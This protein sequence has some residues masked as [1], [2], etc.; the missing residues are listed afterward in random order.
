[1]VPRSVSSN[2]W[3]FVL[4]CIAL[5]IGSAG[6]RKDEQNVPTTGT[7]MPYLPATGYSYALPVM[8]A[9]F[10]AQLQQTAASTMAGNPITDA[11][12][13]LGR[14]LF[15]ERG[16][17]ASRTI[18]CGSCH[19]Q[20]QG[21]SD[22]SVRSTGHTGLRTRRNSMHLV[23]QFYSRRQ[24]WDLR[25]TTLEAQ[26]LMPIQ[27]AVEMGLTL[28]EATDRLRALPYYPALFTEAFGDD[29]ITADRMALALAQF[30]RSIVSYRTR[31]DEGE[32][33]GFVDFTPLEVDGKNLFYNGATRCNQCH[34][35]AN[36][37]NQDARNTGLDMEYTDNGRGEATGNSG[38]Q[39][40]F[41]IPSLRNVAL[42]AP[43]MHDG[44]FNTLEEVVEH[45]NSGVQ[46]HPNL[47]DRLTVDGTIGGEPLQMDLSANDKQALVAF[48]RTLTDEPLIADPR[49]SD[50]FQQ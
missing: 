31:Y 15:Y 27:D 23:N 6:C 41:K 47:D 33:N 14:V 22:A 43:Y 32:A 2:Q 49:F 44:R 29:S 20:E 16:L 1:S 39:G 9:H 19:H 7:R 48:L 10:S 13:T 25:A 28:D 12:A 8:P 42:T 34:M 40:K 4:L 21:F 45:Y 18:S 46:Q 26:V 30:V 37:N 11:G 36:F 38:D 5:L 35:T 3:L 24:F 50:P 17:S